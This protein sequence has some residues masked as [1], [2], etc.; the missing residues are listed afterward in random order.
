M[1][2]SRPLHFP[3]LTALLGACFF[4]GPAGA[5][6]AAASAACAGTIT[7]DGN[8]SEADWSG[9]F[10][11]V[12]TILLSASPAVTATFK[13]LWSPTYLYVAINVNDTTP[14]ADSVNRWE[15][16]SVEIYVDM[17]HAKSTTYQADDEQFTLR[18]N[19]SGGIGTAN[20]H[21]L[22]GML[23]AVV[24]KAGN[25]G[26][27]MEVAIPW[28]NI[29]VTPAAGNV[30]GFDVGINSD[31]NGGTRDGQLVWAGDGNNWNNTSKF[32]DLS[33]V[34]CGATPTRT[35][36]I[37]PTLTPMS[38]S[39][40]S[41]TGSWTVIGNGYAIPNG[42]HLTDATPW[43]ATAMWSN[44]KLDLSQSWDAQYDLYFGT[45]DAGAD[46]IVFVM[47]NDA[48]GLAA[49]GDAGQ[50]ISYAGVAGPNSPITPSVDVEFD[51]Y[52]N[53]TGSP[54]FN[55]P[56][57]DHVGI[58]LNGNGD[59]AADVAGPVQASASSPN[60]EDG[61][62]HRVRINW[63]KAS[64]TLTVYFDGVVRLTYSA[65][66]INTVFGGQTCVY[67]GF[68]SGTGNATNVQE[69]KEVQCYSPTPTF[70]LTPTYSRTS[71]YSL[72]PSIS[73]TPSITITSTK[74]VVQ[75]PTITLTPAPTVA[76]TPS[77]PSLVSAATLATG[78]ISC[79]A[80]GSQ[81]IPF[82]HTGSSNTL[83]L[84][85]IEHNGT[86][87]SSVV[88][89]GLTMTLLRSDPIY[90][91]GTLSTYYS[92]APPASGNLVVNYSDNNCSWNITAE[93]YNGVDQSSPMGNS[94]TQKV[95]SGVSSFSTSVTTGFANS[96]LS[97]FL[98][99][100]QVVSGGVTVTLGG[101]QTTFAYGSGCCEEIYGDRKPA[102]IAGVQTLTYSLSQTKKYAS[103]LVEIKG[104]AC[105][106]TPTVTPTV[107]PTNTPS[108]T[109]T[110]R[111]PLVKTVN[112]SIATFGDTLTYCLNWSNDSSG[113][114]PMVLWDTLDAVLTY[115]GCNGGCSKAGQVV[116]WNLGSQGAGTSGQV[117]VWAKITAYP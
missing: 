47:H 99:I 97:D 19:L 66:I 7:V 41:C 68:T 28:S 48:R 69:A 53:N 112:T 84:V 61:A 23:S 76:C 78:C 31:V 60:I 85:R 117:C 105:P 70:T 25:T 107:T 90:T 34:A 89:A 98:A 71:T 83:L 67:W 116:T 33:L 39:T 9:G 43:Q 101:G 26:Y 104:A 93:V 57:Y 18:Y 35:A 13:T 5:H 20:G 11:T 58:H 51:T 74:T 92:T 22:T 42:V 17:N 16:D 46:G 27:T 75:S 55:D 24:E 1:P 30:I 4:M 6:A 95:A 79:C 113:A 82:T 63:N 29:G 81:S 8:L 14:F 87:P 80:P 56:A 102:P 73:P 91:T 50:G 72:T 10:T 106:P 32:G 36:T 96:L 37:T 86:A 54:N 88:Y 62:W 108:P 21:S 110:P 59:E 100:E 45:N 103:Q 52:Q 94:S 109:P 2:P 64:N 38:C 12:G 65:D 111:M 114:V 44:F 40:P 15:D 77:S 3:F 49:I 115:V